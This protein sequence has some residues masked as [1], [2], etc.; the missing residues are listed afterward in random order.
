M[1]SHR[2][3]AS[4]IHAPATSREQEYLAGWQRARA[5]LLNFKQ[6]TAAAQSQER[7]RLTRDI[8]EP[9]LTLADNFQAV[10][11]HLPSELKDN[12][13]AQGVVHVSRQLDQILQQY[14]L[15]PIAESNRPFDP[16]IHEAIEEVESPGKAGRVVQVVQ[17]GYQLGDTVLRPARVRVAK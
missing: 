17:V 8:L 3:H 9:L 16:A 12:A 1:K 15:Q 5:E 14:G 2:V 6:R 13:W 11:A 10:A 7:T 4:Q